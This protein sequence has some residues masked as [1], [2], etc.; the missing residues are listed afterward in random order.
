MASPKEMKEGVALI[1]KA[2]KDGKFN[3][4]DAHLW[5]GVVEIV[6][7]SEY[8]KKAAEIE[9]DVPLPPGRNPIEEAMDGGFDG[10]IMQIMEITNSFLSDHGSVSVAPY[11]RGIGT[12]SFVV[13]FKPK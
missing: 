11:S 12:R 10:V 9:I 13:D 8:G 2:K 5:D 6:E 7:K 3:K 1:K 4:Y